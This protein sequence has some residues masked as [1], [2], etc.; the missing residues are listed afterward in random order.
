MESTEVRKKGKTLTRKWRDLCRRDTQPHGNLFDIFRRSFS[1]W[2]KSKCMWTHSKD[3][4]TYFHFFY[5]YIQENLTPSMSICVFPCFFMICQ[6]YQKR[7][8]CHD[9]IPNPCI[10][11]LDS[12]TWI[13]NRSFSVTCETLSILGSPYRARTTKHW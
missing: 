5:S 3:G 7:T 4:A 2:E 1:Q 11:L 6:S 9:L 8:S 12:L 10:I 13:F